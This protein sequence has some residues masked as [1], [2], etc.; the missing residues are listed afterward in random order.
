VAPI[1]DLREYLARTYADGE[2]ITGSQLGLLVREQFADAL[3]PNVKLRQVIARDLPTILTFHSKRG[4]D[5]IYR[6]TKNANAS[7]EKSTRPTV[8]PVDSHGDAGLWKQFSNP[9]SDG[10]IFLRTM[11]RAIVRVAEKNSGVLEGLTPVS[12]LVHADVKAMISDF[13]T[14]YL[15]HAVRSAYSV[16]LAGFSSSS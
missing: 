15:S 8:V 2:L 14:V 7:Q 10:S 5:S 3:S 11:D 4:L 13:R 9:R 12:S 16:G 6:V 1:D